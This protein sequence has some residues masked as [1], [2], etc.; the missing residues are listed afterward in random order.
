M[1]NYKLPDKVWGDLYD[2]LVGIM[3]GLKHLENSELEHKLLKKRI[4][5]LIF[6]TISQDTNRLELLGVDKELLESLDLNR[7]LTS[8]DAEGINLATN[9]CILL[10][11]NDE[12]VMVSDLLQF[13]LEARDILAKAE[14]RKIW[15]T[16]KL[17]GDKQAAEA[18][19]QTGDA[20]PLKTLNSVLD[21]KVKYLEE[22]N[23]KVASSLVGMSINLRRNSNQ[24]DAVQKKISKRDASLGLLNNSMVIQESNEFKPTESVETSL[25]RFKVAIERL[26]EE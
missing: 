25:I 23:A 7:M 15:E 1:T 11:H 26:D 13:D 5:K 16:L 19:G 9:F 14:S 12:D 21:E 17:F 3:E 2:V 18:L 4:V 6:S 24:V 20:T 22:Q 8:K 10:L